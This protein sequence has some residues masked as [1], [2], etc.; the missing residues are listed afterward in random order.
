MKK[1]F[2]AFVLLFVM[3][4]PSFAQIEEEIANYQPKLE[5]M[6][7]AR[8][9]MIEELKKGD[10][11]KVKEIKDYTLTLEDEVSIPF[12]RTEL[13]TILV[14]TN[15]FDALG[16]EIAELNRDNYYSRKSFLLTDV[17]PVVLRETMEAHETELRN[18]LKHAT[19]EEE[20]K[21][22]LRMALDWLLEGEKVSKE[23][24]N[25]A[26][27]HLSVY[28][29]S[30]H[31]YFVRNILFEG[32]SEPNGSSDWQ[33][34]P[35]FVHN[36]SWSLGL[37]ASLGGGCFTGDLSELY[38]A[39]GCINGEISLG[40]RRFSIDGG[41]GFMG[42]WTSND[43]VGNNGILEK[44]KTLGAYV[45]HGDFGFYVIQ[46]SSFRMKPYFGVG[47]M[48]FRHPNVPNK[49]DFSDLD[50]NA[51]TY[52]GGL[53]FDFKIYEQYNGYNVVNVNYVFGIAP[54]SGVR[55]L[56]CVHM[57]TV[58]FSAEALFNGEHYS[59]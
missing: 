55:A 43:I 31:E 52:Y 25:K 46:K 40:Y 54:F 8:G 49:T 20:T 44:G 38:K 15:E 39:F 26:T 21:N 5:L 6:Q 56:C 4:A 59:Y 34:C 28:P 30:M 10:F 14:L 58:G 48:L 42:I 7:K 16:K 32:Y 11:A 23:I 22:V 45:P 18:Q 29:N 13:W 9:L 2:I 53:D 50:F 3:A 36:A 24:Y 51:L 57:I 37:K 12:S 27:A 33:G 19:V 35:T 1:T 17:L 47:G 41:I